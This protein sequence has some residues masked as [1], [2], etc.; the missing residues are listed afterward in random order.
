MP[1]GPGFTRIGLRYWL[2]C[3]QGFG[4]FP[5]LQYWIEDFGEIDMQS[6]CVQAGFGLHD[7]FPKEEDLWPA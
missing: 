1:A 3:P 4:S 7:K 6:E 5:S 2:E